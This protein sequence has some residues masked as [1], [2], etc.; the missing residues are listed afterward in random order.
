MRPQTPPTQEE[1]ALHHSFK[2]SKLLI[3][4]SCFCAFISSSQA[5][6]DDIPPDPPLADPVYSEQKLTV[7]K[8]S[9]LEFW[10]ASPRRHQGYPWNIIRMWF[11]EAA[12]IDGPDGDQI[13]RMNI[14]TDP[15]RWE[16]TPNGLQARCDIPGGGRFIRTVRQDG[17][18]LH[19]VQTF[20]N[21]S[22]AEWKNVNAGSCL[23]LSAAPDYE[24]NVG[25]RTYWVLEGQLT[26]TARM[27]ITDPGMRTSRAVGQLIDLKDGT[28]KKLSEGVVFVVSRD[29]RYVLGYSWQPA[30]GL[31]Y[32]RA[33]IVACNHVQPATVDIP[34]AEAKSAR[35]IVFIHEGT[36]EEAYQR[37][38]R[39]KTD[40]PPIEDALPPLD[41]SFFKHCAFVCVDIQPGQRSTATMESLPK[42][43][44]DAG[45][46]P[47]DLNAATDYKFDVAYPNARK[48]ADAC[49]D[50]KLPMIFVHWGHRL[51]DAMDLE[52]SIRQFNVATFGP[53]PSKWPNHISSP[54]ARPADFL[55]VREG[56]YVIAK[57]DHDAFASSNIDYIL[58]NLGV[59]NLV[60]I[61][62]HT[63]ACLGK[64]SIAAKERGYRTLCVK[65][66][67]FSGLMSLWRS[68]LLNSRYDY[69]VTTEEF[70][71]LVES[72][73][74][75]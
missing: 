30:T 18:V 73:K 48:V 31:F 40:P 10:V 24:D 11:P 26:P 47:E 23:Q 36:L 5:R 4:S 60:F 75:R 16:Q 8:P 67:T 37:Y 38:L 59:R 28:K 72:V 22:G 19:L 12:G 15:A 33:G 53:D 69:I 70:L 74:E 9:A 56:E 25:D 35:G 58:R 1:H 6:A 13:W 41:A 71:K 21:Q 52:P 39:W 14:L 27:A 2:P 43:W 55:G 62:G 45:M 65:D 20:Q 57:T 42:A 3:L 32:N 63:D 44:R 54:G 68:G 50:L 49:R 51:P 64:T 46:K 61:G 66:A 34:A 7:G 29:G 17:A